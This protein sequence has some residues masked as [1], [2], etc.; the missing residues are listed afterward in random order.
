MTKAGAAG[1]VASGAASGRAFLMQGESI[2][3]I[4]RVIPAGAKAIV[5]LLEH[6]WMKPLRNTVRESS[7][8]PIADAWI[9][10]D[11]L[12]YIGMEEPAAP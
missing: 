12:K 7:G 5:L 11:A 9:G 1:T 4:K 2:P 3:D 10:R 8:F 6:L